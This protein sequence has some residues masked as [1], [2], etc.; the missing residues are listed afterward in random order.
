MMFYKIWIKSNS[1]VHRIEILRIQILDYLNQVAQPKLSGGSVY[2][3][4][5]TLRATYKIIYPHIGFRLIMDI[6]S[7]NNN[8]LQDASAS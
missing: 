4:F 3:C 7:E 8:M 5:I 1:W 2:K 6:F